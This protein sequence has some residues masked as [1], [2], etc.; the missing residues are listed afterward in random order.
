MPIVSNICNVSVLISEDLYSSVCRYKTLNKARVKGCDGKL[1][2]SGTKT[3]RE[4]GK[5]G[6]EGEEN[7]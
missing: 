5:I 6:R 7:M 2:A 4:I 3:W 1:A